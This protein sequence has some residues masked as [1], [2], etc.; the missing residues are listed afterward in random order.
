MAQTLSKEGKQGS[1]PQGSEQQGVQQ[2][3]SEQRGISRRYSDP[4]ASS[5]MP[6]DFF[7]MN[8]FSA[9][10]RIQDEMDRVF[11]S[12]FGGGRGGPQ[13]LRHWAPAI[14]VSEREGN[15]VV[16]AELPGLHP[17]DVNVEL[18]DGALVIEGER[19]QEREEN[20]GGVHR[21]ERSYG[22]FYRAVPLPDGVSADQ[23][24]ANFKDGVLEVKIPIDHQQQQR[25]RI[26]IQGGSQ[27]TGASQ[28]G[29]GQGNQNLRGGKLP[30]GGQ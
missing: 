7:S 14:E 23:A 10:R 13:G 27:Q 4:W 16:C 1:Q 11:S 22:H 5:L 25:R 12:A 15:Y 29:S 8:P 28:P 3:G 21:T 17:E 18:T 19:R 20:Q 30:G 2:R 6:G 24:H 26:P 9:I